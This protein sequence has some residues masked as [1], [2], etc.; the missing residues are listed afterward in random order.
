MK[1]GF[2]Q[3]GFKVGSVTEMINKEVFA[4][5][6]YRHALSNEKLFIQENLEK[7]LLYVATLMK[8]GG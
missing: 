4:Q 7:L 1:V 5:F 2:L 3:V 8:V 6:I